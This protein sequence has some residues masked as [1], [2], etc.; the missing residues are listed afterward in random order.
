[1]S[2]QARRTWRKGL[3]VCI[4]LNASSKGSGK[5][6][7]H[8]CADSSE[9]SLFAFAIKINTECMS[10]SSKYIYEGHLESS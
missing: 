4:Y 1:M 2:F 5:T 7:L 10:M 8:K 3:T 6:R 9:L